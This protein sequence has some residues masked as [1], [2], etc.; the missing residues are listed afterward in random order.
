MLSFLRAQDGGLS[1]KPIL[2]IGFTFFVFLIFVASSAGQSNS[3]AT[4]SSDATASPAPAPAPT[5]I[6]ISDVINEADSVAVRLREI[7]ARLTELSGG[8][9]IEEQLPPIKEAIDNSEPDAFQVLGSNPSLDDLRAIEK[10]WQDLSRN[11]TSW[12]RLLR[13][14]ITELDKYIEE[15][16]QIGSVWTLTIETLESDAEKKAEDSSSGVEA[17]TIPNEIIQKISATRSAVAET[18]TTLE[19][20]RTLLI[21]TQARV[22]ELEART[23]TVLDEVASARERRLTHLFSRDAAPIWNPDEDR[24]SLGAL[25]QRSADAVRSQ[26]GILRTYAASRTDRFAM[27]GLL[28][29]V[30]AAS[31]FWARGRIRP[32]VKKEPKL[33]PAS[34]IFEVPI[35]TALV[36]SVLFSSWFYPHAPR[37]LSAIL[38]IAALL[39]VVILLRRLV[40]RS[41]YPILYVLVVFYIVDRIQE[42]LATQPLAARLLFLAEM[43][44]A[45]V[46]LTWFLKSKALKQAVAAENSRAFNLIRKAIPIPMVLLGGAFLANVFGFVSL[47]NIVGEGM[48]RAAYA[49][50]LI[51]TLSQISRSLLVFALR[52]PPLSRLSIVKNNRIIIRDKALRVVYFFGIVVWLLIA[53]NMFSIRVAVLGLIR[54]ILAWSISIGS[55]DVSV[56]DVVVFVITVWI[57]VLISRFIRFILEED[58]YPRIDVGGGTSYSISTVLHYGI[59]VLGVLVA[60]AAL[61]VDFTKFAI[62]AGAVGIGVGFGLQNIINNFVSGLILLFE[63]PVKVGDTVQL[64]Q[65]IGSLKRIGLRASVLRKIDGSDVVVPNSQLISEEVI[66]WTMSDKQRRVDIPVG[67]AYGSD[68][69]EVIRLMTGVTADK[70]DI[71][72]EPAPQTFFLG[73]GDNSLDFELKYWTENTERWFAQKSEIISEIYKALTDANIEIPFPQRDLHLRSID[74]DAAKNFGGGRD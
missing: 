57:A 8:L 55:I 36:I 61:G 64:G 46:F 52:V 68:P 42:I 72:A 59:L 21:S 17:Q 62:V 38:G 58:V 40:D 2:A 33:E 65:H 9:S 28:F 54:S 6:T 35:A 20:Q 14:Q 51:Y 41:I 30:L 5:A 15:L 71:L 67:V 16:T 53:L 1:C 56:G 19:T 34:Q 22:S 69:E 25:F 27:H 44:G 11:F 74:A 26:A 48:L 49:A 3:P 18:K 13:D 63:R 66:N 50:L 73:F 4:N 31:L 24:V 45:I 32:Y 47:G 7:R 23:T 37:L 60:I 70:P 43:L 10:E 29:L 12:K 39:P